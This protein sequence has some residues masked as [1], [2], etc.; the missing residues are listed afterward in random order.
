[1]GPIALMGE[2]T[3]SCR[4][5]VMKSEVKEHL[6]NL[7]ISER[8]IKVDEL[9]WNALIWLRTGGSI[10][11]CEYSNEFVYSIPAS[12]QITLNVKTI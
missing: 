2:K 5:F 3:K 1:M 11:F 4:V 7:G 8:T 12:A 10:G 6:E 9:M